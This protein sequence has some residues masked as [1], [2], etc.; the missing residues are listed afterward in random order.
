MKATH[1]LADVSQ[2]AFVGET[3]VVAAGGKLVAIDA[4][5]KRT[6]LA[7][8][9]ALSVARSDADTLLVGTESGELLHCQ[10]NGT[11]TKRWLAGVEFRAGQRHSVDFVVP[12]DDGRRAVVASGAY[13]SAKSRAANVCDLERA[14]VSSQIAFGSVLAIAPSPRG[15]VRAS[16]ASWGASDR[17][18]FHEWAWDGSLQLIAT[19]FQRTEYVVATPHGWL[20]GDSSGGAAFVDLDRT[21]RWRAHSVAGACVVDGAHL[22]I[23]RSSHFAE[24]RDERLDDIVVMDPVTMRVL[25]RLA[26]TYD[27][28]GMATSNKVAASAGG[29]I[30]CATNRTIAI[31]TRGSGPSDTSDCVG[32]ERAP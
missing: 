3:L 21:L 1:K 2:L 16:D 13:S 8:E 6:L 15:I 23:A 22:A 11:I 12:I 29:L 5:K 31:V 30:A 26:Y 25:E 9:G 19:P 4:T 14:S 32:F 20:V 17:W 18:G 27:R 28:T 24:E 10:P 7:D